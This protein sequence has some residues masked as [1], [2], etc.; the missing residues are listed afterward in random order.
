MLKN[1]KPEEIISAILEDEVRGVHPSHWG[2][3]S[4]RIVTALEKDDDLPIPEPADIPG[5]VFLDGPYIH[6]G[7]ARSYEWP[8]P[9][10]SA[11]ACEEPDTP[12]DDVT[13]YKEH[14]R[15]RL[16]DMAAELAYM[17]DLPMWSEKQRK[18]LDKAYVHLYK[19]TNGRYEN[20][21]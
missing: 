18:Q 19:V 16:E 2:K 7:S 15:N 11:T 6:G 20:D 14:I 8:L 10:D 17:A 21:R 13:P 3:V 9:E 4:S 5:A 1:M 12:T